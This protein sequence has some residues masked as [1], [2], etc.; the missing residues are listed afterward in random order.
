VIA[1]GITVA[2]G[3]GHS[4]RP[5]TG[6]AVLPTA[7]PSPTSSSPSASSLT[8]PVQSRTSTPP[9]Q[10]ARAPA[11]AAALQGIVVDEAGKPLPHIYVTSFHGVTQTDLGG[12]FIAPTSD[13]HHG[14][15][16]L[17]TSQPIWAVQHGTPAG[18]DYA[19]QDWF[20][21]SGHCEE[22]SGDIR[23]VMRPGVDVFGTVRDAS[24]APVAGVA[25]YSTMQSQ[26]MSTSCCESNFGTLTDNQGHYVIYGQ[27]PGGTTMSVRLQYSN[28]GGGGIGYPTTTGSGTP[29]DLVDYGSPGCD[30]Y[31]PDSSCPNASPDPTATAATTATPSSTKTALP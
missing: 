21:P 15:C 22:F 8:S 4:N 10:S 24:G 20:A 18:G 23:I 9:G 13:G 31:F 5:D 28:D 16:L 11:N 17:F 30:R 6:V 29:M 27:Q 25:V 1:V 7:T 19:W 26:I 2:V 14:G 12:R 3:P